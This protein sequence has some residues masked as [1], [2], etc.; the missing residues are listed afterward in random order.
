MQQI[1]RLFDIRHSSS[2]MTS[3]WI[4]TRKTRNNPKEKWQ[5]CTLSVLYGSYTQGLPAAH[6]H[7]HAHEHRHNGCSEQE[8]NIGFV[9]FE[10]LMFK[11]KGRAHSNVFIHLHKHHLS[12]R[13]Q[14]LKQRKFSGSPGASQ[15]A[16]AQLWFSPRRS[17][18]QVSKKHSE[19]CW[20]C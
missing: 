6:T 13:R 4:I 10:T 2:G 18:F 11:P 20:W 16:G 3:A 12:R 9:T 5:L 14:L 17:V 8:T 15:S 19:Y 7:T 1:Q